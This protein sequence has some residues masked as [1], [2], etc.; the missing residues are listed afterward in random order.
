MER[1]IC[2]EDIKREI[3]GMIFGVK[4]SLI[5]KYLQLELGRWDVFKNK[6]TLD[7]C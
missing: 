6:G 4:L 3:L 7:H 2:P 1:K 5:F